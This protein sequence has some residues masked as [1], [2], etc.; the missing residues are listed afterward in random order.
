MWAWIGPL[1]TFLDQSRA[2][3]ASHAVAHATVAHIPRVGVFLY[4]CGHQ[5]DGKNRRK[6]MMIFR[7]FA[8]AAAALIA[9]IG[10]AHAQSWPTQR[11]T[12]VVPFGAG[13]VTDILA[14]IFA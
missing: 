12:I 8:I 3:T 11:V 10:G 14:R 5:G 7:V 9:V 13:S 6:A 2:G 4:C 1:S